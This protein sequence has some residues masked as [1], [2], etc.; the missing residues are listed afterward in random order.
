MLYNILEF[1]DSVFKFDIFL[2]KKLFMVMFLMWNFFV[3]LC[4]KI[5]KWNFLIIFFF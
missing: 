4:V 5:V 2:N 3:G 1:C